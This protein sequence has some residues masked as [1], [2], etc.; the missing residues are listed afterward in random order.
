MLDLKLSVFQGGVS[1]RNERR[2][3]KGNTMDS[4]PGIHLSSEIQDIYT[5]GLYTYIRSF[6]LSFFKL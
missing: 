1:G 5:Q 4:L 6:F 2:K 3:V